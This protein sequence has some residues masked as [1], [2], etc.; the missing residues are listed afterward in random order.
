MKK[1]I[2]ALILGIL[3]T[4]CHQKEKIGKQIEP[5]KKEEIKEERKHEEIYKDNNPMKMGIY[6]LKG[7]SLNLITEYKSKKEA[8]EDINIFQILPIKEEQITTTSFGNL[9]YEKWTSYENSENYK[10]GFHISYQLEN[11]EEISFPILK[12]SEANAKYSDYLLVYLYDDYKNLGNN[13][14][15]HLEEDNNA[16][17]TSIKLQ[18]GGYS[19]Q[20]KGAVKLEVYSYDTEDDFENYQYRGNSAYSIDVI[21]E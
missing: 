15:S 9:F 8:L 13:F 7:N 1:I 6:E 17:Y 16:Y 21:S 4:G 14:Y 19:N 2:I 3:L 11:G 18:W 5:K 10:I 20:I 12:P